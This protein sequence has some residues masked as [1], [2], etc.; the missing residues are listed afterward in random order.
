MNKQKTIDEIELEVLKS[1]ENM[2]KTMGKLFLWVFIIVFGIMGVIIWL[3]LN[4]EKI[5]LSQN[6]YNYIYLAL[7]GIIIIIVIV[8]FVQKLTKKNTINRTNLIITTNKNSDELKSIMNTLINQL[9]YKEKKYHDEIVYYAYKSENKSV[10]I[11]S[12]PRYLKYKINGNSVEIETWFVKGN[13]E[14]SIDSSMYGLYI[15]ETMLWDLKKINSALSNS[16]T[17]ISNE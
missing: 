4:H 7:L 1:V 8:Y 14:F 3:G 6:F 12:L 5:N 2:N 15:K 11:S 9:Y 13:K 10:N 16:S 17:G